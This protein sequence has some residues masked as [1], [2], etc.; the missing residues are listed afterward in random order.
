MM[1]PIAWSITA[2]LV[3]AVSKLPGQ[4]ADLGQVARGS[5]HDRGSEREQ[6]AQLDA[7]LT[8]DVGG[9]GVDVRRRH[10]LVAAQ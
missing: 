7:T 6:L 9:V 10:H 8:E 2:R 5:H 4:G 1:M 3:S